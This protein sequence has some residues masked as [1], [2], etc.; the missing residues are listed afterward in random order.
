MRQLSNTLNTLKNRFGWK[1]YDARRH[2]SLSHLPVAADMPIQHQCWWSFVLILTIFT[3][4]S[5]GLSFQLPSCFEWSSKIW[6]AW[7]G[8]PNTIECLKHDQS[9]NVWSLLLGL[10]DWKLESSSVSAVSQHQFN[11]TWAWFWLNS[12]TKCNNCKTKS[13]YFEH[14]S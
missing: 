6:S 7:L 11:F 1:F 13:F 14:C 4:H 3:F 10:V 8:F 12:Q 9:C 2:T 5:T